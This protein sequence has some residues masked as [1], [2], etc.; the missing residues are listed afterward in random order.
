MPISE[1]A[2][3]AGV[4]SGTLW[5]LECEGKIKADRTADSGR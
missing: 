4:M 5:R 2:K 1:A 3:A